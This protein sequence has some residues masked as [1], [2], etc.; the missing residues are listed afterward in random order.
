[1]NNTQGQGLTQ[2]AV[3]VQQ[4]TSLQVAVAKLVE[5]P[6]TELAARVRDEMLDNEALEEDADAPLDH[7]D[8]APR[9]E[10]SDRDDDADG[11]GA[12]G[13]GEGDDAAEERDDSADWDDEWS[14]G[15]D[16]TD[17]NLA[18]YLSPDDVP[19]H[20][21]ARP[22][23]AEDDGTAL[24]SATRSFYDELEEQMG[25][26]AL[27]DHEREVMV[28][29]IGSLDT[30]GLLRKDL[31]AIADELAIYHDT[32]TSTAELS[33]LLAIL[34]TFEPH[35]IGA[36]SLQECLHL[37]LALT[38]AP[39]P[40][41]ALALEVIDRHF[42][43][44]TARRWDILQKRLHADDETMAHV[45]HT[46]LHLNPRP[47]A[48]WG[49]A[50]G[51]TAP[52]IIPDFYVT[53]DDEGA[54]R[55]ALNEGDV[56]SLY[57]SPSFVDS[58]QLYAKSKGKLTRSQHDAYV[59]AR[60][61]VESAQL[62]I[63]LLNRR[64]TTLLSVMNAI[65]DMQ[66][67]F[68]AE[69]DDELLLR[70]LTLREVAARTGLDISTVSRVTSSKYVQTAFATYPLKHFFSLQFTTADGEELSARRVK[71]ALRDFLEK[72]DRHHP[73]PDE[74]LARMLG[75]KGFNVARRTV[76]KYR[77]MLGFPTARLRKQ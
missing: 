56:P 73:L 13:E 24:L 4:Q 19:D 62:F 38:D 55:V 29:L 10:R 53:L 40:Y 51:A 52:T 39:T 15:A 25:E 42:K 36:R 18:D 21:P 16:G 14:P 3:Q 64:R 9:D 48:A 44:F 5:L 32:E 50:A 26:H 6:V 28:Y 47:G 71:A 37:Q 35:G 46:L 22:S 1:M 45:Q 74:R 63:N 68:F 7:A 69:D 57:V 23:A 49:E 27:T 12:D 33:R 17:D 43:H 20:L 70:P 76:A 59:Y 77:D 2:E 72:E 31:G 11:D 67:P 61:K 75:E 8:D 58:I 41:T 34:Q 65:V 60:K 66:R 54:P 30:D